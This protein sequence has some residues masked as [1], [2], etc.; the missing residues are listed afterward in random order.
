M[1]KTLQY[2]ILPVFAALMTSCS[3]DDAES[4]WSSP[5]NPVLV[6]GITEVDYAANGDTIETSTI[7][8]TYDGNRVVSMTNGQ[9]KSIYHYSGSKIQFEERFVGGNFDSRYDYHYSG[10]KL[11]SIVKESDQDNAAVIFAY[12]EEKV[13]SETHTNL[14]PSDPVYDAF[15]YTFTHQGNNV[16]QRQYQGNSGNWTQNF[17]YD[18]NPVPTRDMNPY[19]RHSSGLWN[20]S[21]NNVVTSSFAIGPNEQYTYEIE[22]SPN[23][24]PKLIRKR[25]SSGAL[26]STITIQY[27]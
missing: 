3:G 1:K 25:N 27:L 5:E 7:D 8:L 16:S 15:V 4:G 2:A 17:T 20:L 11:E 10:S 13:L 21:E 14:N 22:Y 23:S 26:T 12:L 19:F 9:Y 24:F 6:S 18:A